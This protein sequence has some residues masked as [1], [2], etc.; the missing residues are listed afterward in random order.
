MVSFRISTG[1]LSRS[2]NLT[3][4]SIKDSNLT[5]LDIFSQPE[6][7]NTIAFDS[8]TWGGGRAALQPQDQL[9][10]NDSNKHVMG[11]D[12][13]KHVRYLL[14]REESASEFVP[15]YD[16]KRCQKTTLPN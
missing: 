13:V 1:T 5:A 15:G 16:I 3:F 2:L 6:V 9:E 7:M 12:A 4:C 8:F 11:G 10:E 14:I